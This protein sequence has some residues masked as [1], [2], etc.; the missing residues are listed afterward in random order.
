MSLRRNQVLEV[1]TTPQSCEGKSP[2]KIRSGKPADL[3]ASLIQEVN[4][5]AERHRANPNP[6]VAVNNP[7]FVYDPGLDRDPVHARPMASASNGGDHGGAD[8]APTR[9]KLLARDLVEQVHRQRR[10]REMSDEPENSNWHGAA[11]EGLADLDEM[12][13][14]EV[15]MEDDDVVELEPEEEEP[16]PEVA[17]RWRLVGRYVCQR[18]PDLDDMTDHFNDVWHLRMGVNLAPMGKNWFHVTLFSEG[19]FDFVAR[20]GPW[21]YRGYPLLVSKIPNGVRPSETVLNTVPIWVQ[22]YDLPWNRQK[23]ATAE[24]IGNRLGKFLEADLDADGYSPYDF[25][26]MRVDIPVDKRI[27]ASITT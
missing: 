7:L 13:Q 1:N 8:E 2:G 26:R 4:I 24:L 14:G 12:L 20:G 25:L 19:D 10:V 3:K 15:D 5:K 22:A 18:K 11:Q 16:P 9:P 27:K 21:I 23:K 17:Q 6:F